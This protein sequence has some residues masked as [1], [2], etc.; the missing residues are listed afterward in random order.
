MPDRNWLDPEDDPEYLPFDGSAFQEPKKQETP[1]PLAEAIDRRTTVVGQRPVN[2]APKWYQRLGAAAAG[3]A[4]GL[5]NAAGRSRV[6][7][8]PAIEGILA[9]GHKRRLADWQGQVETAD[10][11]VQGEQQKAAAEERAQRI[12]AEGELRKRQMVTAEAQLARANR[13]EQPPSPKPTFQERYAEA[14]A[15]GAE[16]EQALVYASGGNITPTPPVRPEKPP[17]PRAGHWSEDKSGNVHYLRVPEPG[18]P[19]SFPGVGKGVNAPAPAVGR[20]GAVG[21]PAGKPGDDRL[22]KT[23]MKNPTLWNNL[24]PS[25]KER[26]GPLLEEAG[27]TGFEKVAK[28]ATSYQSQAGGYYMRLAE[29]EKTFAR[30]ADH[31]SKMGK[32]GQAYY[33]TAPY[34]IQ[35]S[36]NKDLQNAQRQ[37]TE[38]RLRK[39]SGAV[40]PPSEYENDKRMYFPRFGDGPAQLAQKKQARDALMRTYKVQAG[41]RVMADMTGE[42]AAAEQADASPS[43]AGNP[44]PKTAE[45][46]L[47]LLKR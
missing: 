33:D 24:P 21:V 45:E 29:A 30:Q 47:K 27:F 18:E 28:P 25:T 17:A 41:P 1:T 23:I 10:A 37:F 36:N 5:V 38:A 42:E 16:H 4:A 9:P 19:T 35:S 26:I 22:V 14:R 31:I 40:I 13:A 46:Y 39:E 15:G 8:A 32:L 44:A 11:A 20:A 7:A 2:P 34:A 3:G 6:D 12:A 43:G